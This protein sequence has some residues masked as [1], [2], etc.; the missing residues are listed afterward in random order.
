M[1]DANRQRYVTHD[2]MALVVKINQ[3][4]RLVM[5]AKARRSGGDLAMLPTEVAMLKTARTMHHR[6]MIGDYRMSQNEVT[7]VRRAADWLV[8]Q[9]AINQGAAEPQPIGW[10]ASSV[11]RETSL[12]PGAYKQVL[13]AANTGAI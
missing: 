4:I 6:F 11:F 12:E 9:H 10:D 3:R 13:D 7:E 1:S 2:T 8:R 5:G